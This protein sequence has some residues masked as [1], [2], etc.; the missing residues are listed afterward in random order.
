MDCDCCCA[1]HSG[2]YHVDIYGGLWWYD[3]WPLK[4]RA[5]IRRGSVEESIPI[6]NE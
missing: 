1:C 3:E 4:A 5:F 2:F 6:E